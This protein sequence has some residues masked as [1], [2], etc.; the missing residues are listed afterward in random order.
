MPINHLK[1]VLIIS[2]IIFKRPVT[3]VQKLC[4]KIILILVIIISTCDQQ[5]KSIEIDRHDCKA[6]ANETNEKIMQCF[7]CN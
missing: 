2:Q 7:V 6:Y 3:L 4:T 1:K 5:V